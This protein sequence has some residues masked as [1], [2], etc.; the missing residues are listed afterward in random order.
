MIVV[1]APEAGVAGSARNGSSSADGGGARGTGHAA[2]QLQVNSFVRIHSL[3]QAKHLNDELGVVEKEVPEKRRWRV[4]LADSTK[5]S[6]DRS[7]VDIRSDNLIVEGMFADLDPAARAKASARAVAAAM[8]ARE[9]GETLTSNLALHHF[10]QAGLV[11]QPQPSAEPAAQQ[12]DPPLSEAIPVPAPI[13]GW[14]QA[15]SQE[16][17]LKDTSMQLDRDE[18]AASEEGRPGGS[19]AVHPPAPAAAEAGTGSADRR[20]GE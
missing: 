8:V 6:A 7:R 16:C 5:H 12:V 10:M 2:C 13:W 1:K 15:A 3:Q 18:A 9:A 17:D 4:K 19:A 14:G 11:V 20:A